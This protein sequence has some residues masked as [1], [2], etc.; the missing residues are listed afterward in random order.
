[1]L[2]QRTDEDNRSYAN[3]LADELQVSS[4]VRE[5]VISDLVL[6][7]SA[8]QLIRQIEERKMKVVSRK[9]K[10]LGYSIK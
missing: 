2:R 5:K 6:K 1:M 10:W 3:R 7:L 4:E 8:V 9:S